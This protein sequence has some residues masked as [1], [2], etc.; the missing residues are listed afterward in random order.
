MGNTTGLF[1]LDP[2]I[3]FFVLLGLLNLLTQKSGTRHHAQIL[4]WQLVQSALW[5]KRPHKQLTYLL[6]TWKM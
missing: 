1:F 6:L 3:H 4:E 5:V 2:T